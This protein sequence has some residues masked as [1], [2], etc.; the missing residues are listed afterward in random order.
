MQFWDERMDE[1]HL[2]HFTPSGIALTESV[3]ETVSLPQ[4][5]LSHARDCTTFT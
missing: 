2:P 1:T 3:R 4:F 5:V